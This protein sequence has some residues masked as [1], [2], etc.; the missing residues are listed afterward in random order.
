VFGTIVREISGLNDLTLKG[1]EVD[2][3]LLK[4]AISLTLII[5][6]FGI[7]DGKTALGLLRSKIT[8]LPDAV[9]FVMVL[10][11]LFSCDGVFSKS[12]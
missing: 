2:G 3:F 12:A 1:P 8:L 6:T 11:L 10:I 7:A 5:T 9:T 4:S